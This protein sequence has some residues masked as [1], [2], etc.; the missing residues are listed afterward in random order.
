VRALLNFPE[1]EQHVV[2]GLINALSYANFSCYRW[3]VHM[4]AILLKKKLFAPVAS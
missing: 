3:E 4:H 2:E 1:G